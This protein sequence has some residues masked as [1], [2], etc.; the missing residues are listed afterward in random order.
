MPPRKVQQEGAMPGSAMRA[1][2]PRASS[3]TIL[4]CAQ[5]QAHTGR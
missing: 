2:S 1:H 3:M 5:L 4:K